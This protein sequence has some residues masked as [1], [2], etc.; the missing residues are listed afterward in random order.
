MQT[1][2]LPQSICKQIDKIN[3]NFLWGDLEGRKKVHL[4]NWK[5]V[6]KAKQEGG[7]GLRRAED[8]NI[9]LLAKLGWKFNSDPDTIWTKVLKGKYLHNHSFSNWPT[10]KNASQ[11]WR[12]IM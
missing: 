8:Q 2:K 12:S 3:R 7:L 5:Q 10:N 6:C 4:V 11:I 1:S 9:A